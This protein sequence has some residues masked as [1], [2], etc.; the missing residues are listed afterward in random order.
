VITGSAHIPVRSG[1]F[2]AQPVITRGR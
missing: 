2:R 1:R